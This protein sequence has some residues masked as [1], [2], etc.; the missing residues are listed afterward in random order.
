MFF[1]R[2]FLNPLRR[3]TRE[4]VSSPQRLHAAVLGGF[5]G[6]AHGRTLWRLDQGDH[7]LELI[8]VSPDPP[9]LSHLAEMGG[10]APH[11]PEIADYRPFLDGITA[12][13][14]YHFR[15][16]ANTVRSTKSGVDAGK[17]GRV[18]NVGSRDSQEQWFVAR[19][20][21]AGF[22]IPSDKHDLTATDG[23]PIARRNLALTR[24]E[25]MRFTKKAGDRVVPVTLATAQFDGRLQVDD[26]VVLRAAL[27][28]GIGRG[29]AYGCG[30]LTLARG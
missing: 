27:T 3:A 29:K 5:P 21:D 24:R 25:T 30:L 12:G 23:T 16:R 20:Q 11:P 26:P 2:V 28:N 19:A 9:D 15:I 14:N 17:R 13:A 22:H 18:I 4:W 1:S 6:P 8:V 7:R 10:W